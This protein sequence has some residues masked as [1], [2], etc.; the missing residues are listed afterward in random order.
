MGLFMT[1]LPTPVLTGSGSKG[2]ALLR[3]QLREER[4]WDAGIMGARPHKS[5][6][7]VRVPGAMG[8]NISIRRAAAT[9]AVETAAIF[10]AALR[11]MAF[12]PK[13]HTDEEDRAFVHRFIESSETWLAVED[14]KIAGL[15]CIEG[16]WLM[17]LYVDPAFHNRGIGTA[18]LDRVKSRRPDG[19][20]LWTFQ[21]NAAVLRGIFFSNPTNFFRAPH[22]F[23]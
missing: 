5:R 11:S 4:P 2:P 12:F 13:L 3:S 10:S 21:A 18:L 7:P 16:D 9:D 19:F 15:A 17:H 14:G 22:L 1:P 23:F 20:Q 8:T 6:R